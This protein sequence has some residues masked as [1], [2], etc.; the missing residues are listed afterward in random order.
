VS[1]YGIPPRSSLSFR[2]GQTLCDTVIRGTLSNYPLDFLK[3]VQQYAD[4][5]FIFSS[6]MWESLQKWRDHAEHNP[7]S[8]PPRPVWGDYERDEREHFKNLILSA[9]F[10]GD[11]KF[12][13][14]LSKMATRTKAPDPDMIAVRAV[15]TAFSDLFKGGGEDDWP[16]KK[17]VRERAIEILKE[18]GSPVPRTSSEWARVFRKAGL[19]K[20]PHATRKSKAERARATIG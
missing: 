8:R 11:E 2:F 14:R 15:I 3:A 7:D 20:L 18:A 10:Y 5:E 9:V 6:R 16:L 12:L 17:S 19:S 4:T 1:D 13:Q